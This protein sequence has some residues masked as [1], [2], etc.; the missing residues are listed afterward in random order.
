MALRLHKYLVCT[1]ARL[2][3]VRAQNCRTERGV[4]QAVQRATEDGLEAKVFRWNGQKTREL[5]HEEYTKIFGKIGRAR[6]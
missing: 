2:Q 1:F 6:G 4:R 5:T 3:P